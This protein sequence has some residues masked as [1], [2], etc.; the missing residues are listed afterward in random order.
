MDTDIDTRAGRV[1][2]AEKEKTMKIRRRTEIQEV[3]IKE[4]VAEDGKVFDTEQACREHEEIMTDSI[5]VK[6]DAI[7]R[8]EDFAEDCMLPT[9][10]SSGEKV[11]II[12]IRD[13]Q[14]VDTLTKWVGRYSGDTRKLTAN[15]IGRVVMLVYDEY[16]HY[17]MSDYCDVLFYDED[18]LKR[19]QEFWQNV[20][21]AEI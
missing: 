6:Y 17:A 11:H 20:N 21:K 18:V 13:E 19:V 8:I 4:Y 10:Y 9:W 5:K 15:D 7:P 16:C 1:I 12:R 14:D 3:T 2:P